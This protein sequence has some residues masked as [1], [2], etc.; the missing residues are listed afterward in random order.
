[1]SCIILPIF[2]L[3]LVL[4]FNYNEN[5]VERKE[6]ERGKLSPNLRLSID[7]KGNI[8]TKIRLKTKLHK[9]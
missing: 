2:K 4:S 9:Q 8:S 5:H 6:G 1:M 3:Y 7:C